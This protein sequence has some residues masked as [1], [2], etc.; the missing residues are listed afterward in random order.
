MGPQVLQTQLCRGFIKTVIRSR[1]NPSRRWESRSSPAELPLFCAV[2]TAPSPLPQLL[3]F[4]H[5]DALARVSQ[6]GL[7][8]VPLLP[9]SFSAGFWGHL[10][11]PECGAGGGIRGPESCVLSRAEFRAPGE[12]GNSRRMIYLLE[13]TL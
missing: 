4:P 6:R 12:F 13:P 3:I 1:P 11:F 7:R 9:L 10:A 5:P 8:P 2:P